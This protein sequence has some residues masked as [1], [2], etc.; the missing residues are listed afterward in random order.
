MGAGERDHVRAPDPVLDEAGREL[1]GD[2][3]RPATGRPES[4]PR[5]K[6]ASLREPT[7]LTAHP[8]A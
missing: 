6:P 1:G 3:V 5:R 7:R 8:A 4:S 2:L